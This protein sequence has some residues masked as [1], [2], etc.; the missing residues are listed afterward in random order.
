VGVIGIV[1]ARLVARYGRPAVV[2]GFDAGGVGRGS[3]RSIAGFDLVAGLRACGDSLLTFGGHAMA[4]G[5][6]LTADRFESFRAAFESVCAAAL[7]G[8][9]LRPRLCVDAWVNVAELTSSAF[10][11]GWR[12]MQPFGE[13]NREPIWGLRGVAVAGTPR[14]LKD[15]HVKFTVAVNGRQMEAIGFG[16]A[17]REIPAGRLDLAGTLREDTYGGRTSMQL[18]LA[19]LR[20]SVGQEETQ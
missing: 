8:Q 14:V 9:D 20:V 19:D 1:A 13:G 16:M 18:H 12:R 10:L 4:A 6:E 15:Q 3:G 11:E 5:L 17:E 7:H 2:V